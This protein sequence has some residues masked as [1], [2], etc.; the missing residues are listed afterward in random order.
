MKGKCS[1]KSTGD[2]PALI[3]NAAANLSRLAA[4]WLVVILMPPIL[5]RSLTPHTY[6]TWMLIIQLGAYTTLFESALQ[7]TTGRFVAQSHG[8]GDRL[9]MGNMM[10]S[11][12]LML[13][14]MSS[15]FLCLIALAAWQLNTFFPSIPHEILQQSRLALLITS[16]SLALCLPCSALA[17]MYIGLQRNEVPALIGGGAKLFGAAGATWA[18]KHHQGLVAMAIW[19]GI[20]TLLQPVFYLVADRAKTW[21]P[22]IRLM[23]LSKH[24]LL[25]FA[26]FSAAT[27]LSQFSSLLITGLDLPIVASFDFE[28]AAYYAVAVTFSNMLAVPYAA[29]V[30][31]IMPLTAGVV[32]EN[33]EQ[34]RG[35][36]LMRT[37]QFAT[38]LLCL[39]TLPLMLGMR[40]FLTLWVGKDYASHAIVIGLVLVGAQFIRLTLVPY[41]IVGFSAGQQQRML[42]S[43]IIEGIVN[44]VLSLVLVRFLGAVGVAVGTLFGALLGVLLHFTVSMPRTDSVCFPRLQL[45]IHG[46]LRPISYVLPVLA[47]FFLVRRSVDNSPAQFILLLPLEIMLACFLWFLHFDASERSQLT[48]LIRLRMRS[49][50]VREA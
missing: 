5:V 20:G 21:R 8:L 31:T 22:F 41:A 30:S 14:L 9:R 24:G 33:A 34:K 47:V 4:S 17:G 32:G 42:A 12:V 49:K 10:S 37:T 2:G 36:M 23:H 43:P 16:A 39:M 44:L 46:I 29:I 45:L 19:T 27:I 40:G 26:R 7:M 28:S 13:T 38:P 18:A 15:V 25:E 1:M 50:V 11:S 48:S 3:K 6:S 35:D